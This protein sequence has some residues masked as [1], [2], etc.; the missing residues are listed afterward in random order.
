MLQR[1]FLGTQADFGSPLTG[2][3]VAARK[4]AV[5]DQQRAFLGWHLTCEVNCQSKCSQPA[6]MSAEAI[7]LARSP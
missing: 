2:S 1:V 6:G 5:R 3:T 4:A 7:P